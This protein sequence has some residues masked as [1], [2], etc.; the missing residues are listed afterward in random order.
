MNHVGTKESGRHPR[1][2]SDAAA[3]LL[4]AARVLRDE[5]A[6]LTFPPPVATVYDPLEYAWDGYRQY[7]ERYAGTPRRVVFLGMNPG[8][9]GMAQ[10]GVPFG[11]VA[12]VRDLLG[13]SPAIGHPPAEHPKKPVRGM[14]CPRAEVSGRRLW[15]L[16]AERYGSLPRFLAEHFVVNYSPLLFLAEGGANV[17]PEN[18]RGEAIER[19]TR[20]CDRHLCRVIEILRPEWL[21]GIGRFAENAANRA[22]AG[23][24]LKIG[25]I[26]H[27]SPASPAANRGWAAAATAA[28]EEMGVWPLQ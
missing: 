26:L 11:E 20:A 22:L 7:V 10:T 8:P 25:S 15:G 2:T 1:E 17:T 19:L 3:A 23:A 5:L 24:P 16:F 9:W 12:A 6:G 14:A 13:L 21:I 4:E 18:L 28:L 27:P